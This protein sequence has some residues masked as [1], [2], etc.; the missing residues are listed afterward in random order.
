MCALVDIHIAG[1]AK[2]RDRFAAANAALVFD[3]V[4][5][6]LTD[7]AAIA[8]IANESSLLLTA[9][10]V[11][12][13]SIA[14]ARDRRTAADTAGIFCDRAIGL[15][16]CAGPVGVANFCSGFCATFCIGDVAIVAHS[17]NG[18]AAA[19]TAGIFCF[20]G[21]GLA[22]CSV[23]IE[24]TDE[25]SILIASIGLGLASA[26]DI[27]DCG[28]SAFAAFVGGFCTA[29]GSPISVRIA[30]D[31]S[32]AGAV[33]IIITTRFCCPRQAGQND[34]TAAAIVAV[35]ERCAKRF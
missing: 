33:I 30:G 1:I 18:R 5:R 14:N 26:V 2:P 8:S 6:W 32:R 19:N 29:G 13:A 23:L 27:G 10:D 35:C 12:R 4:G 24:T 7:R 11:N 31:H 16:S 28:A 25:F 17:R 22:D 34:A 15:A 21:G 3:D 20:V 9:I